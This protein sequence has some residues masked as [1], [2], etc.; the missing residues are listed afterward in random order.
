MSAFLVLEAI[1]Q[2]RSLLKA[3]AIATAAVMTPK[4]MAKTPS[5]LRTFVLVHG[6][7]HGGWCWKYVQQALVARG[8]KVFAPT[9]TGQGE[10]HHLTRADISLDTHITDITAMIEAEE[11]DDVV[12]VGHSY[13]GIVISGVADRLPQRL[14][15]TIYLDAVLA[16]DGKPI[17]AIPP[18]MR[19]SFIDGFRIAS[20]PAEMFNVPKDHPLYPWVARRLTDMPVAVFEKPLVLTGAWTKVPRHF[21]TCTINTLEGPKLGLARA[22]AEGWD[23]QTIATGHDAMVTAPK[24]LTALLLKLATLA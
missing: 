13:G 12:L 8:H 9:L 6:A 15:R 23:I 7:W 21:I 2:R 22:K 24:E 14:S 11:L 5:K 1:M 16:E 18:A 19:A 3:A 17:L 4:A 20:F 10:R